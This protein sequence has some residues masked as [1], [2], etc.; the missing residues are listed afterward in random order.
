MP[1][2]FARVKPESRL[3]LHRLCDLVL[4]QRRKVRFCQNYLDDSARYVLGITVLPVSSSPFVV[5]NIYSKQYALSPPHRCKYWD[6]SL[7]SFPVCTVSV[8]TTSPA[9]TCFRAGLSFLGGLGYCGMGIGWSMTTSSTSVAELIVVG[10]DKIENGVTLTYQ[11][12][13]QSDV[14]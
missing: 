10:I 3:M 12:H 1:V 4:L 9:L 8:F 14:T 5:P 11:C 6:N 7:Y 2:V 13:S